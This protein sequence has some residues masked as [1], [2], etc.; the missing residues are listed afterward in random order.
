MDFC[1][2]VINFLLENDMCKIYFILNRNTKESTFFCVSVV[3]Y[4]VELCP[5]KL[6]WVFYH[7]GMYLR[8]LKTIIHWQD[9]PFNNRN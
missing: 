7:V 4:F 6:D 3:N 5:S 2:I 1:Y 9:F 8:F